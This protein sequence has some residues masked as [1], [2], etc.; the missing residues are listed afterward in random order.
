MRHPAAA[1]VLF[2]VGALA[3]CPVFADTPAPWIELLLPRTELTE[4]ENALTRWR[5]LLPSLFPSDRALA[6]ALVDL[7]SPLTPAPDAALHAWLDTVQPV[8][9]QTSLRPG[10]RLQLPRLH[11]PETPFP[12]HQP[13]RQLA[14]LRVIALKAAWAAGRHEEAVSLALENL[15]LSRELLATQEGLIPLINASGIWQVSLDGVY[16]LARQPDLTPAHAAALQTALFRDQSLVVTA[17]NRA[18]RGEFTFFTQVVVNRLPRTRD[19]E[20]ILSGIGSL[21]MTPPQPPDEDEPR[22]A[23]ATREIFDPETTLQAASEDVHDWL[24][25]FSATSRHPRGLTATR[26]YPRLL[27][28]A[29]EI[30]ALLR[31][32]TQDD[33]PTPEQ[34]IAANAELATVE[35]PVGKLFLIITTSQWEP[36]SASV[37]RREAQRSALTGLLAWRRLGH[38]APWRDLVTAGLLAEPPADP[39]STEP[40]RYKLTPPAIWSVAADGTDDGGA[41]DGENLGQP[42]DLTW[43]LPKPTAAVTSTRSSTLAR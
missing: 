33:P 12:D 19:P 21:G 22:L 30:P 23:V 35:N 39:F 11:G 10:E 1:L 28:Y 37:F 25:A 41:G 9:A 7:S 36:L 4:T 27:R 8:L 26:T 6:E 14:T 3:P 31:Y 20:L 29:R 32:A 34:L 18:F 2:L 15:A 42:D 16:W 24:K 40:L 13:L 38:P 17:L 43:P 5:S